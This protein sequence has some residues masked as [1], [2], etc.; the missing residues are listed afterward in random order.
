MKINFPAGLLALSG[1]ITVAYFTLPTQLEQTSYEKKSLVKVPNSKPGPL[2]TKSK[3]NKQAEQVW[4][5]IAQQHPEM[6]PDNLNVEYI[7][8]NDDSS[9]KFSEGQKVSFLIPQENKSYIGT[10]NESTRAFG[11]KVKISSGDIE[12]GNEFASFSITEGENTTF[13]TVA[14]GESIYQVEIDRLSGVGV[15]MDDRE[16]NQYRHNEDG[17]LP[18]PEGVS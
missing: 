14:T 7:K 5:Q 15:V 10:I 12:N 1:I 13:V 9:M 17:I 18:P 3:A 4:Q 11:G 6:L 2:I 8:V 16:L